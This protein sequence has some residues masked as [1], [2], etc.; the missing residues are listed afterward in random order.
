MVTEFLMHEK[1][2]L[3]AVSHTVPV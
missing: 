3:L 1:C 2:G